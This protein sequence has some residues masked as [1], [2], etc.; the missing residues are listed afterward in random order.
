MACFRDMHQNRLHAALGVTVGKITLLHGQELNVVFRQGANLAQLADQK[1]G[2]RL[3]GLPPLRLGLHFWRGQCTA[4]ASMLDP[5]ER[6]HSLKLGLEILESVVVLAL[7]LLD[8]F[9]ELSLRSFD[10]LFKQIG[11]LSQVATD[12]AH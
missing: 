11:P 4:M 12:I 8:M 1:I 5:K 10:L 3:L 6:V 9:L 2:K 7:E